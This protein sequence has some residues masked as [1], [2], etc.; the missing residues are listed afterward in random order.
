MSWQLNEP[1]TVDKLAELAKAVACT[2]IKEQKDYT[3][4]ILPQILNRLELCKNADGSPAFAQ[5]QCSGH[6]D[7]A[8]G[9]YGFSLNVYKLKMRM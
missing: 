6:Y 7:E 3:E 5:V 8:Q 9:Q 2:S 1:G 4:V